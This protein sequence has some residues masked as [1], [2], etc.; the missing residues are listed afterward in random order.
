MYT[1]CVKDNGVVDDVSVVSFL[2]I[3]INLLTD[4][5]YTIILY[6]IYY[7]EIHAVFPYNSPAVLPKKRR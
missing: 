6:N 5:I 4:I 7:C 3:L 2:N 1:D